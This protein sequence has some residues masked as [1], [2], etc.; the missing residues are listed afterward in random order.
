VAC[1]VY[2]IHTEVENNGKG[3]NYLPAARPDEAPRWAGIL[4]TE[5]A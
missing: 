3:F 1:I 2:R 5:V 4:V